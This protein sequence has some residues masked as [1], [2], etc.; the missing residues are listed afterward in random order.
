MGP[1]NL[2]FVSLAILSS[3]VGNTLAYLA[4]STIAKKIKC[5]EHSPKEKNILPVSQF[6]GLPLKKSINM[7]VM[8]ILTNAQK[9]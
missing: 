5:C 8:K 4:H 2:G 3:L 9:H 6:K 7:L 1:I